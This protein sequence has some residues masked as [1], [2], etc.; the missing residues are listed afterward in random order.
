MPTRELDLLMAAPKHWI[1]VGDTG[2]DQV[3]LIGFPHASGG[4]VE[5]EFDENV[6]E[7]VAGLLAAAQV[8][9]TDRWQATRAAAAD[10]D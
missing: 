7:A 6:A 10:T 2:S 9:G 8:L 3:A 5:M 4:L 1:V